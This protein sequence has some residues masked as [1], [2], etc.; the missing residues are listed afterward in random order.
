MFLNVNYKKNVFLVVGFFCLF[1]CLFVLFLVFFLF[2]VFVIQRKG[3][4]YCVI[5]VLLRYLEYD[6]REN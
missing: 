4:N 1:V 3:L 6:M 5:P 2:F